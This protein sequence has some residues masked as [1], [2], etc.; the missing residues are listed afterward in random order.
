MTKTVSF[1][2]VHFTVAFTVGYLLT[3]SVAVGGL[4]A[5]VEPLVNTVAYHLHEKAWAALSTRREA[6]PAAGCGL[7]FSAT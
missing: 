7:H 6:A 2:C 4:V 3:G 1:A 5:L